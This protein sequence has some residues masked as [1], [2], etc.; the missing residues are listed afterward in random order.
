MSG[1]RLAERLL[2]ERPESRLLYMSG[3][4][5]DAVVSHGVSAGDVPFLQ[6]PFSASALNRKVREVLDRP[7][8]GAGRKGRR[9]NRWRIE[10]AGALTSPH[11]S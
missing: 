3:Y 7:S 2:A 1:R 10:G 9:P 4:T 6:K 8:P 11:H 5:D